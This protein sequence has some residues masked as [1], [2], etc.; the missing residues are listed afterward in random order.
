M[1]D[2]N[3]I[4]A[5]Y[6]AV[7][8]LHEL[9]FAVGEGQ[10]VAILGA[11]GAGKTTLLKTICGLV[12]ASA[13]AIALDGTPVTRLPTYEIARRG[14]VMVPEGRQILGPLTVAENLRLGHLAA[15]R[16]GGVMGEDIEQV[17]A[18]FPI[19]A[20]RRNQVA[21]QL[22]GGQQQMLAIGR[23]LMGRPRLLLLDEPSLGLAP[24]IVAQ[25]FETLQRV[26]QSGLTMLLVEQNAKRAL[27]ATEYAYVM[28]R[29][30]IVHQGPSRQLQS[31]P[32]VIEHYLGQIA[33]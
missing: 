7:A 28:E 29:G 10:A 3:H 21:G 15:A 13:G 24:A 6:G 9:S 17:F 32:V 11:N 14:A 30:R 2:V 27:D 8:V 19:L 16:R 31:D 4:S 12:H 5:G 23:A 18:L 26:H 33:H 1:L 22:S 20:E 25:V